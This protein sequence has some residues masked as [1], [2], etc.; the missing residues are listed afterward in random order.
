[1][2][3]TP[4][5]EIVLVLGGARSGKSSWAQHYVEERY[6]SRLFL[7]TAEVLDEEM[8]DRVRLHRK[9]R[10]L[11]WELLE[12]P[13]E[14]TPSLMHR[15]THVDAVLVDCLTVWLSNVILR[16]GETG[17]DLRR[18]HLIETLTTCDPSVVLVSNEVGMGIVP[19]HPLGRRFRDAAGLLNQAVAEVAD[20]VV[21]LVAGLPMDLKGGESRLGDF[22]GQGPAGR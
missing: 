8:A 1:M 18:T 5:R 10:G 16:E 13:L 3:G 4:G 12:E 17:T 15:C 14:L 2:N 9:A 11:G 7:A 22:A 20:R 21:L 19:D 6:G